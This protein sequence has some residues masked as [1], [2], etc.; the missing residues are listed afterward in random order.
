MGFKRLFLKGMLLVQLYQFRAPLI[1]HISSLHHWL[2]NSKLVS[3]FSENIC[4]MCLVGRKLISEKY[5]LHI[6]VF[7]A[8]KNVSHPLLL[9]VTQPPP[10]LT[11]LISSCQLLPSATTHP[12]SGENIF[13]SIFRNA[14]K[15]LKTFSF[16]EIYFK[17]IKYFLSNQT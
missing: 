14:T 4:F 5:I 1:V 10:L 7:G 3:Q 8:T 13:R 9:L 11:S 16:S 17:I 12:C 6:H 2:K 15:H